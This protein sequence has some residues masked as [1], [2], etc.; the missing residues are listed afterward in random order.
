MCDMTS[1]F[2]CLTLKWIKKYFDNSN[3]MWKYTIKS[4]FSKL[5]VDLLLKSNFNFKNILQHSEFYKEM[6]TV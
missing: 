5:N 2:K 4:L 3:S 6:L 1:M